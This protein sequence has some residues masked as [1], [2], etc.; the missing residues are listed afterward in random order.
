[1]RKYQDKIILE[2][3]GHDHFGS[4]RYHETKA[5]DW[6]GTSGS[7][8]F[9]NFLVAPSITAWYGNN[10]GVTVLEVGDDLIARNLKSSFLNLEATIGRVDDTPYSELEFRNLD[11]TV[12]FGV[13][14]LTAA[15]IKDLKDRLVSDSEL[16][17]RYMVNKIGYKTDDGAEL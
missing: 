7:S 5:G 3:A 2:V 16:H 15:S 6:E 1:M 11:W 14:D 4:L 10:P 8:L 12:D 9:H 17:L 13:Q